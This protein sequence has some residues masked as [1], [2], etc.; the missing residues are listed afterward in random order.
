[1]N[2]KYTLNYETK[3]RILGSKQYNN[4]LDTCE[5][6]TLQVKLGIYFAIVTPIFITL[7]GAIGYVTGLIG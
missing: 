1:M 5:Q 6:A 4:M 7:C 3:A 2:R